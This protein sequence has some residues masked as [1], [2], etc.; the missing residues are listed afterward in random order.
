MVHR[1]VASI[2]TG[3]HGPLAI[4]VGVVIRPAYYRE[5]L[6]SSLQVFEDLRAVDVGD[7]REPT[8]SG[9]QQLSPDVALLDL[10]PDEFRSF[11]RAIKSSLP[12]LHVLGLNRGERQAELLDLIESGM[13]GF[14]SAC[15]TA[16][17]LHQ[18]L[19]DVVRGEFPCSPRFAAALVRRLNGRY[20][21]TTSLRETRL[22]AREVQIVG[23]I[24]QGLCNKEIAWKL[25]IDTGTVKNHVHHIL[26][27]LEV[28]SRGQI[29]CAAR[30]AGEHLGLVK[31]G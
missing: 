5:S 4:T 26:V 20:A 15:D 27:K 22:T 23:L 25:S 10:P 19:R 28:P 17:Q 3:L 16:T 24:E 14:A 13:S 21:G 9:L 2:N 1:R 6:V 31:G 30:V 12:F 18:R 7:G 29:A 8:L 11:L